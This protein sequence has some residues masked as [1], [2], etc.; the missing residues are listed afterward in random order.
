MGEGEFIC[1]VP[2]QVRVSND[3]GHSSKRLART[4]YRKEGKEKERE[5]SRRIELRSIIPEWQ[6]GKKEGVC[7]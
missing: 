2:V 4:E 7:T 1:D 6:K 5:E 3:F